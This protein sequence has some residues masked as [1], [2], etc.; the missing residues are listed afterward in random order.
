M[1]DAGSSGRRPS[2]IGP[3]SLGTRRRLTGK[4][5]PGRQARAGLC[6]GA[7]RAGFL[8]ATAATADSPPQE[9]ARIGRLRPSPGSAASEARSPAPASSSAAGPAPRPCAPRAAPSCGRGR[10]SACR[11]PGSE[12]GV[13]VLARYMAICRGRTMAR[14]R[15]RREGRAS[16][17]CSGGRRPS[18]CPRCGSAAARASG[19][20]RPSISAMPR[21]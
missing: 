1:P 10:R 15:R 8:A 19:R 4:Q 2:A 14:V 18:G 12:R 11:S 5:E 7:V 13:I 9:P 21:W 20:G 16:T 17:R 6:R 3:K